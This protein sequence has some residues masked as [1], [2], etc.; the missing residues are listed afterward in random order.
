MFDASPVHG[1]MFLTTSV[2]GLKRKR[3]A[4][5][6]YPPP[7]C[8][9]NVF[10]TGSEMVHMGSVFAGKMI[11]EAILHSIKTRGTH[12][13]NWKQTASMMSFEKLQN[14][15]VF[16][17]SLVHGAIFLKASLPGLKKSGGLGAQPPPFANTTS[18]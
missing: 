6:A 13:P 9:H 8:K 15:F 12:L 4:W 18:L 17:A 3:G 5:G 1:A 7:I 2:H 16:G 10:M 11:P 14:N